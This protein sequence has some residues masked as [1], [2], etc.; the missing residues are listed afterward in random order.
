[1]KDT[2]NTAFSCNRYNRYATLE[3]KARI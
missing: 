1:M 3:K 2:T